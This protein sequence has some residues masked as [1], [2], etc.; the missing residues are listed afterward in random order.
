MS[1]GPQ[2][3]VPRPAAAIAIAREGP[4]ALEIY[5]VR[6][7]ARSGFAPD[8]FVF[9]GGS[10]SADD[11][12]AESTPGLCAAVPEGS[13]G[14]GAGFRVAALRE[15]FEEAGVLLG[16]RDGAMVH[17]RSAAETARLAGMRAALN[18]R[19]DDLI[20]LASRERLVLATDLLLHWSHW[21][22]PETWPR[23]FDTHFFLAAMP[24]G[25]Q[26]THD[27][28]ETSDGVWVAPEDALARHEAGAFP[29]V[30]ATLHQLRDLVGLPDMAAAAARFAGMVVR[31]MRPYVVARD[32]RDLILL[33]DD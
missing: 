33:P 17:P 18:R 26:A 15:C 24:E 6:R 23:R 25:Q 4:A 21:I 27:P 1:E 3:V 12:R 11:R 32:G 2:S 22:T 8:V 14:L 7:H 16:R 9:P 10:V 28:G 13:I 31:T 20:A 30:F 29:L 5:M 19:E